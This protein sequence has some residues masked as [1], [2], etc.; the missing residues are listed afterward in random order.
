[1][2]FDSTYSSVRIPAEDF[3]EKFTIHSDSADDDDSSDS[4][5]DEWDEDSYDISEQDSEP[6]MN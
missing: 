1:M 6:N 4:S 3:S 2:E 5:N